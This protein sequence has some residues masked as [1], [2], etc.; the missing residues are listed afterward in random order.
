MVGW[1]HLQARS[2]VSEP[3]ASFFVGRI[4]KLAFGSKFV[5]EDVLANSLITN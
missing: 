5:K 2:N 1:L 4:S 3:A